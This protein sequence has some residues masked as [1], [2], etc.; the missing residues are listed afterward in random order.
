MKQYILAFLFCVFAV[1]LGAQETDPTLKFFRG[2]G[3]N[4]TDT[5]PNPGTNTT[6]DAIPMQS[7]L[8][9]VDNKLKNPVN[10]LKIV[11]QSQGG[12][13]ALAYAG[14][15]NNAGRSNEIE[16]IVTIGGPDNGFSPLLQGSAVLKSKLDSSADV[17][18]GGMQSVLNLDIH[19]KGTDEVL[20]N[21]GVSELCKT[22]G[23][24]DPD[25]TKFIDNLSN[26]GTSYPDMRPASYFIQ[27]NIYEA[28]QPVFKWVRAYVNMGWWGGYVYYPVVERII[29][30]KW[31]LPAGK[32]YGFIVGTDS[33][34]IAAA[35]AKGT[36]NVPL[37]NSGWSL[38]P[39]GVAD[40][41][42]TATN[43]A[44][45][46]WWVIQCA[47][48]ADAARLYFVSG[49]YPGHYRDA[50]QRAADARA[51]KDKASNASAWVNN[52]EANFS[53]ILGTAV[54][55]NDSFI[56]IRDQ[57]IDVAQFGGVYIDD[58]LNKGKF[59]GAY[60][61][62]TETDHPDIWGTGG[63]LSSD[64]IGYNGKLAKWL[65]PGTFNSGTKKRENVN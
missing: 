60:N 30:G 57:Y 52:T 36:L 37:G 40:L 26:T 42:A 3:S 49:I 62:L 5:S 16:S 4:F 20:Q 17:I 18:N 1:F 25:L 46:A 29:P 13:R 34:I 19:P 53:T 63:S 56:P 28:P 10:P 12:L 64:T 8:V 59:S 27:R 47:N 33:N 58:G 50:C 15:L 23:I 32:K 22:L 54:H 6:S 45:S 65:Y 43:L 21:G 44:S 9:S 7:Q 14:Y 38:K 2:I 41:Y 61:H 48:E 24:K 39:S 11:G 35:D 55:E 31:K 51:W